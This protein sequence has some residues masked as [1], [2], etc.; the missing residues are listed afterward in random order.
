MKDRITMRELI[1]KPGKS[2]TDE[3]IK[4]FVLDNPEKTLTKLSFAVKR[5]TKEIKNILKGQNG[6]V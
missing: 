3:Q 4:N 1:L 2:W 6:K 5:S